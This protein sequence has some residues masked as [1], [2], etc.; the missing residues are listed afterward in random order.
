MIDVY[1]GFMDEEVYYTLDEIKKKS[2]T[3]FNNYKEVY[4][5]ERGHIQKNGYLFERP[6][7]SYKVEGQVSDPM[8]IYD[9]NELDFKDKLGA[10]D[11]NDSALK[12]I[13]R[14]LCKNFY[15]D[16]FYSEKLEGRATGRGGAKTD[17]RHIELSLIKFSWTGM[18]IAEKTDIAVIIRS[19]E[20]GKEPSLVRPYL[21]ACVKSLKKVTPDNTVNLYMIAAGG[22][23]RQ[24]DK[25]GEA[26]A[27]DGSFYIGSAIGE[28]IVESVNS[29][30]VKKQKGSELGLIS[31]YK[32][33]VGNVG[34]GEQKAN[35]KLIK[36][37]DDLSKVSFKQLTDVGIPSE[38]L[39]KDLLPDPAT[40]DQK[41]YASL[42]AGFFMGHG[43]K[44][45]GAKIG[46][47]SAN[48]EDF[49]I[50]KIMN[51]MVTDEDHKK[52]PEI[53][54]REV[55][56]VNCDP[57][58]ISKTKDIVKLVEWKNNVQYNL[59]SAKD[60]SNTIF[61][62]CFGFDLYG[63]NITAA[64]KWTFPDY[65]F[66]NYPL[67]EEE[68][69]PAVKVFYDD[70]FCYQAKGEDLYY[71]LDPFRME[72]ASDLLKEAADGSAFR[73]RDSRTNDKLASLARI[74][75]LSILEVYNA[76]GPQ[77]TELLKSVK[78]NMFGFIRYL[79]QGFVNISNEDLFTK[80][81]ANNP[82][83]QDEAR[84]EYNNKVAEGIESLKRAVNEGT[85]AGCQ[86]RFSNIK[87]PVWIRDGKYELVS[88]ANDVP[89]LAYID[90]DK[91]ADRAYY[92]ASNI[93]GLEK[94]NNAFF[95]TDTRRA[96][97]AN[98]TIKLQV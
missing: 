25:P 33:R 85:E 36:I 47:C 95:N 60:F 66:T 81:K 38:K 14:G 3:E 5:I 79:I 49:H 96:I 67:V 39:L 48:T 77:R 74:I 24:D 20:M 64:L 12:E 76:R 31:M 28:N 2:I 56:R 4:V 68:E 87:I 59:I 30:I 58:E 15:E 97:I 73:R 61:Y 86:F 6:A 29:L 78:C 43:M 10:L 50:L 57:S 27:I 98:R 65:L 7:Y 93:V 44:E 55:I 11:N 70:R 45:A 71:V 91:S 26:F 92:R 32:N 72:I 63:D 9:L 19:P 88:E 83:V 62:G 90:A 21:R 37:A 46:L 40:P 75:P 89:W 53:K 94:L 34:L 1:I 23:I 54:E 69:R 42:T 80:I 84:H 18:V 52:Y 51:S 17:L 22:G 8:Q 35:K 82:F 41:R 16:Y 13:F